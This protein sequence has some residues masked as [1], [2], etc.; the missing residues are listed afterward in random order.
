MA[1]SYRDEICRELLHLPEPNLR[2]LLKALR[3]SAPDCMVRRW[4]RAIGSI[5]DEDASEMSRAIEEA[6]GAVE[7]DEMVDTSSTPTWLSQC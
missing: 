1:T 3:A 4:N 7:T 5:T 6:F 2:A